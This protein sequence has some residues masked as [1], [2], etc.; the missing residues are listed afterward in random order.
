MHIPLDS[1][2]WHGRLARLW[3]WRGRQTGDRHSG[4]GIRDSE[5][6]SCRTG[7]KVHTQACLSAL[8][9]AGRTIMQAPPAATRMPNA[10]SR[11]PAVLLL[12]S[13]LMLGG[14]TPPVATLDLITV[15]RTG[16][17]DAKAAQQQSHDT[18]VHQYAI[19]QSAL[20]TAFDADVRLAEAGKLTDAQGK[21]VTLS[22]Q[23][24][25]SARKGYAAAR[26][27][28]ATQVSQTQ[29]AHEV[30]MDNIAAADEALQMAY[31]LIVQ[32]QAL[33][34]R[35]KQYLTSLQRKATNGK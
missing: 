10:G 7:V 25:I 20:D 9:E 3:Q 21:P 17:A 1:K 12:L 31:D 18:L 11:V 2:Q 26:D 35:V 14:C 22:G 30:R 5:S 4:F 6:N 16:L 33:D 27:A 34:I 28:L 19:E 8:F 32:Q 15:A 13:A 24:V 29:A 23:W